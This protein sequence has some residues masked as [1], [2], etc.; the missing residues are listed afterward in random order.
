MPK[1]HISERIAQLD[2]VQDHQE[3][4]SL[5]TCYAFPWDFEYALDLAFFRTFA[6]PSISQILAKT[7]E[8]SHRPRKRYDDTALIMF[9]LT[10]NGY[11]SDRGRRALRRMNQMHGRLSFSNDDLIYVLSIYIYEPIRWIDQYGWRPL[12][13][14]EKLACFHFF[15]EVGHRM[16]AK[17]IPS[18]Y[19]ELE[20]FNLAYERKHFCFASSN[21]TIA[22]A[23]INLLLSLY[24]P[25]FLWSIA[26]PLVLAVIDAPLLDA[27][28]FPHPPQIFTLLVKG[29]LKLRA[30][31][32]KWLPEREV[33]VLR[34]K[35]KRPTYPEGYEIEEL[36][37][38]SHFQGTSKE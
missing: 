12:T 7:G 34:T 18:D 11:D 28:G 22:T 31:V 37:T 8:F 13:Q 21:Q 2:P 10:E 15:R 5:L 27:V 30:R 26:R 20:Q 32:L 14:N 35:W 16:N 33:P 4:M 19:D 25:K 3:I 38:F 23:T 29:L 1:K 6:L 36:G 24:L 17:N 9:E